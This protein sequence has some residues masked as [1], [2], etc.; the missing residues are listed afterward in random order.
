M[1]RVIFGKHLKRVICFVNVQILINFILLSVVASFSAGSLASGVHPQLLHRL[2]PV[3]GR[4]ITLLHGYR[5]ARRDERDFENGLIFSSSPLLPDES[6]EVRVEDFL[7]AWYGSLALGLTSY[8]PPEGGVPS[9]I[10]HLD[11]TWFMIGSSVFHNR[12]I[13]RSNLAPSLERL[14]VGDLINIRR[15]SDSSM[16]IAINGN[17]LGVSIKGLAQTVYAVVDLHGIVQSVRT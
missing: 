1:L 3:C 5:T 12:R 6:F 8:L 9:S 17:D 10:R 11:G 2:S 4:A 14:N 7:T 15:T 13:L 16:R